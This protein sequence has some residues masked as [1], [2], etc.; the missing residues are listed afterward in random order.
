MSR[1]IRW[2]RDGL[3]F[4]TDR[5]QLFLI[6]TPLIPAEDVVLSF[7]PAELHSG[8]PNVVGGRIDLR[9]AAPPGGLAIP[10]TSDGPAVAAVP[11]QVLVPAGAT[12]ATFP[13]QTQPV[14][15]TTTVTVSAEYRG[16]QWSGTLS[17]LPQPR[18]TL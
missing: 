3:A 2:G 1:L 14:T 15:T 7:T 9:G 6:R 4:H 12:M 5:D 16:R 13:V 10:L 18:L 17:L 8:I 11:Q